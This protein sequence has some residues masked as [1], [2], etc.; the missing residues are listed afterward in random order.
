MTAG[1]AVA[2]PLGG[3]PRAITTQG[4]EPT[5][6][7]VAPNEG[8]EAGGTTV[9]ITGTNFTGATAVTFGSTPAKSFK[10][11]SPTAIAAQSPAGTGKVHVTVTT[12]EGTSKESSADEFTYLVAP[13]VEKVVPTQGPEAGGTTVTI[14]GTHF[15][16]ATAVK[17]GSTLAKSFEVVSAT[18]IK[19]ES[20]VGKEIGRAHV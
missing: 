17:F 3:G 12:P 15:T 13:T 18:T 8:P 2:S 19:A 7:K 5:V 9:T 1:T 4:L 11:E 10:V 16:G 14:T 6:E 20:P